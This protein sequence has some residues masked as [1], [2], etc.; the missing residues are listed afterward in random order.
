MTPVDVI[1]VAK[2]PNFNPSTIHGRIFVHNDTLYVSN[3]ST[4]YALN[5][6]TNQLV[7]EVQ[8]RG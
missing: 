5:D 7:E 4:V 2:I 8:L 3:G 6:D 1:K